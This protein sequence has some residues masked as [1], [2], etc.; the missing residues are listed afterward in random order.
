MGR[1]PSGIG[2]SQLTRVIPTTADEACCRLFPSSSAQMTSKPR[3]TVAPTATQAY[4][5]AVWLYARVDRVSDPS[6]NES[7]MCGTQPKRSKWV[8][9][10]APPENGRHQCR[11]HI[12]NNNQSSPGR[13]GGI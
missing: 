9:Y 2:K 10:T 3:D 12:L 5:R 8:A 7:K 6:L 13:Q 1:I 11:N 4:P